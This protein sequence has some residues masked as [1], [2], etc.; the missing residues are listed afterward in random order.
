MVIYVIMVNTKENRKVELKDKKLVSRNMNSKRGFTLIEL[1]VVIAI[2]GILSSIVL[3]AL[4]G[5]RDKAKDARIVADLTQIR[6]IAEVLYDGD[7]GD[8]LITQADIAK[9][10]TDIGRQGGTLSLEPAAP[11]TDYVAYSDL[12][13]SG[14]Y[15]VDSTGTAGFTE[16]DPSGVVG[17][18]CPADTQ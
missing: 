7:Y 5:A 11:T 17:N 3:V 1:L 16:T 18:V 9:L 12:N 6:S 14:W 10:D 13:V 8:V 15:C 4:R 2:I